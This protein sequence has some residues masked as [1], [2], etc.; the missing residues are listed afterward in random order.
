MKKIILA[1]SLSGALLGATP[2]YAEESAAPAA[3][4]VATAT[5]EASATPAPS[6]EAAPVAA[7]AEAAPAAAA[8]APTAN[9][10]DD[11]FLMICSAFVILMSIP[12]LALFYGGLVRKKNML[13]V[14]MQ[15]F[16]VF[17]LISVLWMIYGY[18]IAFTEGNAFFGSLSKVFLSGVTPD[19]LAATWSKATPIHEMIYIVFQGAFAA[20]T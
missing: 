3:A 1:L 6:P 18:S 9:K 7:P 14:L 12:G 20:I 2:L 17:S 16:T 13:S 19:S 15:V 4:P 11:A 10:G 8:P 5:V